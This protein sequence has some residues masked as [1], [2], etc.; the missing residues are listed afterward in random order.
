MKEHLIPII[1]FVTKKAGG[2]VIVII[3]VSLI[4]FSLSVLSPGDPAYLAL[5]ADGT[6]EPSLREIAEMR[7]D[8]GLN[9]P[10]HIQYKNWLVRF[11]HGDIGRSF[12]NGKMINREMATRLP[13]TLKVALLSILI[14]TL[15]GIGLGIFMASGHNRAMD[16]AGQIIG[17][18]LISV[19]DFWLAIILIGI[20]AETLRILPTS[21]VGSWEHYILPAFA[22]AAVSIGSISRLTRT[23]LLN[24][25]NKDYI[26]T[27]R[28]KG[29]TEK[30]ILIGHALTNSLV[31][32]TTALGLHFGHTLGGVVIVESIFAIPGIGQY[33]MD[34]IY[35]RDYPVIQGFVV[36]SAALFIAVNFLLDMV[37]LV[38]NPELRLKGKSR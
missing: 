14:S 16:R 7:E 2:A 5:I 6:A 15:V 28:S 20:F 8:L 31:P 3:G 1:G 17:L 34:G 26:I 22:L 11:I 27:A 25:L 36:Y 24:E 10:I 35:N 29:I 33:A 37:Y 4:A 19:P 9:N 23:M 13:Y 12:V 38:I 18:I 21:G 30:R 32:I